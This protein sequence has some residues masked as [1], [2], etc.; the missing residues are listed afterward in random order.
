[1]ANVNGNYLKILRSQNVTLQRGQHVKYLPYVFTEHG[2]LM[3]AIVLRSQQAIFVS[4]QVV[5]NGL[6]KTK[7]S[8]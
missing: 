8:S 7:N 1:M 4:I 3:S 2:A 6:M 5:E